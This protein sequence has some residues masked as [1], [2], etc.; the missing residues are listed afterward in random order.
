M[1]FFLQHVI[2]CSREICSP[3]RSIANHFLPL[4][5]SRIIEVIGIAYQTLI[6]HHH[7]RP[8]G[9]LHSRATLNHADVQFNMV[10]T[11]NGE[12]VEW[13]DLPFFNIKLFWG[14]RLFLLSIKLHVNFVYIRVTRLDQI[15]V[16]SFWFTV[17]VSSSSAIYLR[18]ITIV[19]N[20][21][22]K[23]WMDGWDWDGCWSWLVLNSEYCHA[24]SNFKHIHYIKSLIG[25]LFQL[26]SLKNDRSG[27]SYN[28]T[29]NCFCVMSY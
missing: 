13:V 21:I 4:I 19:I 2:F 27:P 3:L 11:W 23:G 8:Y 5:S 1:M 17:Y 18:R 25:H 22:Y 28:V 6:Y 15:P 24:V 9:R 16:Q 7:F 12:A 26:T 14:V 10:L 20:I 29:C